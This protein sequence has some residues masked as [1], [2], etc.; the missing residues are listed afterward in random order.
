MILI[1]IITLIAVAAVIS[2]LLNYTLKDNRI[3]GTT[4][5]CNQDCNQG[6]QCACAPTFEQQLKYQLDDEFN[7]SNWPFPV[8]PKP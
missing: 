4:S 7:G 5:Y 3:Y 6:R 1:Q 8:R 2:V